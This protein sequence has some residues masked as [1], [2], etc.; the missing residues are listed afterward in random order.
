ML[1]TRLFKHVMSESPELSNDRYVLYDRVMYPLTAQQERMTQMIMAREEVARLFQL[2][3]LRL[4]SVKHP[5]LILTIMIM[6]EMTKGAVSLSCDLPSQVDHSSISRSDMP[7]NGRDGYD[8][9]QNE[10]R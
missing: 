5:P 4:P 8:H 6:M 1:L 2:I 10:M 9:D 7:K 3:P